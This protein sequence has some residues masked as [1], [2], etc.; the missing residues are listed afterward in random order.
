MNKAPG[1]ILVPHKLDGVVN[2][3]NQSTQGVEAEGSEIHGR[4]QL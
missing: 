3:Y 1:S 2:A 4:L